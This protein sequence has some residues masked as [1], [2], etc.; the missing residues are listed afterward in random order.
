M[1]CYLFNTRIRCAMKQLTVK[2]FL[3]LYYKEV[4]LGGYVD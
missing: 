3:S 1:F 2:Q 4:K